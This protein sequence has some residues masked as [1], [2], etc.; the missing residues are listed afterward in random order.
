[1]SKDPA[2]NFH[3]AQVL[4][5]QIVGANQRAWPHL[6]IEELMAA[7]RLAATDHLGNLWKSRGSMLR[8]MVGLI[9]VTM[10]I[11]GYA[12]AVKATMTKVWK[13]YQHFARR[14]H[15]VSRPSLPKALTLLASYEVLYEK[16]VSHEVSE[17]GRVIHRERKRQKKEVATADAEGQKRAA[18]QLVFEEVRSRV[19]SMS[20]VPSSVHDH[21]RQAADDGLSTDERRYALGMANSALSVHLHKRH[22][23][24]ER[25]EQ[26]SSGKSTT[27][28]TG[29]HKPKRR[30]RL[31][32]PHLAIVEH[33][34]EPDHFGRSAVITYEELIRLLDVED[35]LPEDIDALHVSVLIVAGLIRPGNRGG[36]Y[37][38][39]SY[40][41]SQ[42]VRE[43]TE[44]RFKR[45][46]KP[47]DPRLYEDAL[48]WLI[49]NG[50][51][52]YHA[53]KKSQGAPPLSLRVNES[54]T[55]NAGRPV[56]VQVKR[57][58]GEIVVPLSA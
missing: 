3:H 11:A 29:P 27:K 23:E 12:K 38:G 47:F 26:R 7:T 48:D 2:T 57:F 45:L 51:V 24:R 56:L 15:P 30:S 20:S 10:V 53:K 8:I 31:E 44:R 9:T 41:P 19:A 6:S 50:V 40:S 46:D 35:H 1:I 28:P 49:K 37:W 42:K 13:T 54:E 55:T 4:L 5:E 14:G 43:R 16:H 32:A 58:A 33:E 22:G 36:S 34:A 39:M 21:I 17:R 18:F 25:E 52:I